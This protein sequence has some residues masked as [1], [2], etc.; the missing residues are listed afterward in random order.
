MSAKQS[1]T[2]AAAMDVVGDEAPQPGR[3]ARSMPSFAAVL[4]LF[5]PKQWAKNV[6]VFAAPGAGGSLDQL[7]TLATTTV[8]FV[9]L[10]LAASG[11]Y[12]LNDTVDV[13]SDRRHPKKRYRPVASGEVGIGAARSLGIALIAASIGLAALVGWQLM[14]VVVAY[15]AMTTSYTLWLKYLP[16]FDIVAVASGFVLRTLAGAAAAS[17]AISDWFFIVASFGALFIVAGK[18][19]AELEGGG[20]DVAGQRAVLARY[21]PSFLVYVQAV[22]SGVALLGYCLWAFEKAE[23]A[24]GSIPWYQLSIV[25]FVVAF[26]RYALR[27]HAGEGD[28]PEDIVLGDRSI[29]TLGLVWATLFAAAV[30][31]S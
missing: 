24:D 2:P 6:L 5:R 28:T 26:L 21:P 14:A 22:A 11:T 16:V 29:R 3:S 31:T 9:I 4:R 19:S 1:R 12:C 23:L 18:R 15:L 30:Y 10:C 7:D 20:L 17:E 8:A 25:P 13:E 27:L